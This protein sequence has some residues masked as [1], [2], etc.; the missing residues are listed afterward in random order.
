[1][2]NTATDPPGTPPERLI[3][4][5]SYPEALPVA[6]AREEIRAAIERHPVVVVAG[7]T[8]SGKTTQLPK[9][10]LELGR[11]RRRRIG[12]TQPRRLAAR[13][14]AQRIAEELQQP[15][16]EL[17]GY[18]VRFHEQ[19]GEA[20]AV[21]LMTDGILL[22]EMARDR[23][24]RQYDTL[25]I[26][27]AHERSLN[28]DFILGYLKRLLAR[29]DD[30]KVIITS[31]T[32][33]EERFA[34]HFGDAPVIRVSGRSY[35]VQTHYL[36]ATGEVVEEPLSLVEE[37]VHSVRRGDW[38][39][40]GDMLVFLPGERD[41]RDL[42]RRLRP[43]KTLDVLPLYARLSQAEQAR[44]FGRGARRGLRVVLATNVAE[45]SVTV[46]G[47]RYVID[48]GVARMS[49]YSYRTR[50][51]R[52]PIEP[53][54]RA[55]ANQR[56]GRCGRVGPGVCLRLYSEADFLARPEFTAPEIQR[57]NLAAVVLQMLQLGLGEVQRFPFIDPPDPRLVRD[58]YRLLEELG[59]VDGRQR[60]TRLGRRMAAFPVD[61]TL[62]RMLLAARNLGV[63][64]ELLVIVS[65]LAIQDPRERPAEKQQQA[66]Q[67]HARFRHSRSDFLSLLNL[68]R[69]YEAQRQT[70]SENR[71]RRLCQ[72]EFLSWLRMREWRDIHRQLTIACRAQGLHPAAELAEETDYAGVHRALL[73][74]L[75][76]N[77]AQQDERRD[78]LGARNRRMTV[79]PGSTLARKPPKW[80]LAG[81][82]VETQ[83]VYARMAAAIEPE[84]LLDVNPA[85]LRHQYYEPRWQRERGRVVAWRR[86]LLFG[87]TVSDRV[88]VNYGKQAPQESRE[89]LIREGL[90]PG[91]WPKAPAF[92]RHNQR[93]QREVEDLESRIRRRDLLVDEEALYRFYDERLPTPLTTAAALAAWLKEDPARD[94]ALRLSRGDLLARDP[95]DALEQFPDRLHWEGQDY[96]LSYQFS[97]G[98][99]ADGVSITVPV[100][101]LN[102]V[103]RLRLQWLVPGLLREKCIALVKGL[104]KA[105]R[106]QLV[107]VPDRVDR[108]LAALTPVDRPLAP[109]LGRA[110]RDSGGPRIDDAVWEQVD[111]DDYY[112]M[113][114]RIV[115]AKGRLLA[116]GRDIDALAARFRED[117]RDE[118]DALPT[119]GPRRRG[120]TAWPAEDVPREWTFRQAGTRIVAYPA[121]VAAEDRVDL[122]LFDYPGEAL[123]AHRRGLARLVMAADKPFY[124]SLRRQW[125]RDNEASLLLAAV[126]LEREALV[127]AA[128]VGVA[129]TATG[130]GS[131]ACR[132]AA[133]FSRALERGRRAAQGV[134]NDYEQVLRSALQYVAQVRASLVRH[135]EHYPEAVADLGAQ[136][137]R[138][139]ADRALADL[140]FDLLRH[141]PRFT[142][143]MAVRAER[144]AAN[145][146]RD[147]E[148]Q[149]RLAA[150]R[151]PL[152]VLLREAPGA[153]VLSGSL[154]RYWFGLEEL[155]V[156]LFAQHLGTSQ[157]VSEKRLLAQ[158]E[159][160]QAW[161]ALSGGRVA[162]ETQ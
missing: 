26:D 30:L 130:L 12:H 63:L 88:A 6:R 27:E 145:Y 71:L 25:I 124:R 37:A 36:L 9:I 21:K 120:L 110:L 105:L 50:V 46:P 73:T 43:E 94:R 52:L 4:A 96:R 38:G 82:V 66:D 89:L 131:G 137:Q 76:A 44:V 107:P 126:G 55:S 69:Y 83:R 136:Q 109:A 146:R 70:L 135:G 155:A 7:E 65:A 35:P 10:C 72:R 67:S 53:I 22:S 20:T 29:R 19:V 115:D 140:P 119:E 54:S 138:L 112:H 48:P 93:L 14:V 41:I 148:Q 49:H 32:I 23:D 51:Q 59:A 16:G 5:I 147:Q 99:E 160:V 113:N 64:P 77:I 102:R 75:L 40:P 161:W 103:P 121:L 152:D 68:W 39:E 128:L 143:A 11:G 78:Y 116:Q 92:L 57:S 84:W 158:W 104:P 80:L 114:V 125:L 159:Q 101:L 151:E 129:L 90:I 87:L 111:L 17:V 8:G 56:M 98:G 61:P 141:F 31:A 34:R 42:A 153:L 142:R 157:P 47:I 62:S 133:A 79:F 45:T 33:D 150:L 13:T 100:A 18:Q 3:P 156:S 74:G 139:F 58:G 24:L 127:E 123:V 85:L 81:E 2:S 108:A 91:R 162:E 149:A 122:D 118:V 1:V 106:R 144:L 97:P 28:I 15:L 60:L 132:E 86:T 134:A 117:T 154:R 95:G